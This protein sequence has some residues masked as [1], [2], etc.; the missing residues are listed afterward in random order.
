MYVSNVRYRKT[1]CAKT[2]SKIWNCRVPI[3]RRRIAKGQRS[4]E[5][6]SLRR[7]GGTSTKR[8]RERRRRRERKRRH[9]PGRNRKRRKRTAKDLDSQRS[10]RSDLVY[11][12]AECCAGFWIRPRPSRRA[13]L[14]TASRI[15]FINV[16]LRQTFG[17]EDRPL[18]RPCRREDNETNNRDARSK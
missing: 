13:A 15:R 12:P 4:G 6:A 7:Q 14:R 3:P 1:S 11:L 10:S 8:E 9:T 5:S 2:V 17:Q 18:P 16:L